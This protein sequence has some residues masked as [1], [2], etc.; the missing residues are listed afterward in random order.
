MKLVPE[1]TVVEGEAVE[2]AAMG[3]VAE[4]VV[5]MDEEEEGMGVEDTVVDVVVVVMGVAV[6]E[7]CV[8]ISKVTTCL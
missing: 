6:T 1:I 5:V 2:V 4:E 3:V 8:R 7:V